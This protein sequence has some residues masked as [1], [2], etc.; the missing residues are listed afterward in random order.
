MLIKVTFFVLYA[1]MMVP[2]ESFIRR[3]IRNKWWP[4]I[5]IALVAVAMIAALDEVFMLCGYNV[6]S[7]S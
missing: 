3:R 5:L 6:Y 1:W 2:V 4:Y 7:R